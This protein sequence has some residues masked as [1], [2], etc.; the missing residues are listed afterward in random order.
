MAVLLGALGLGGLL[1][2]CAT[3]LG[4]DEVQ[5]AG[6]GKDGQRHSAG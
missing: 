6:G 2:A 1:A 4:L 5:Y 3:L